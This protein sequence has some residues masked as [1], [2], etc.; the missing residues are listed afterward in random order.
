MP[1]F[2][3]QVQ[4]DAG[5]FL[6]ML[7]DRREEELEDSREITNPMRC[8]L[9][10]V[11]HT[12]NENEITP[13]QDFL[14]LSL[15]TKNLSRLD[16]VFAAYFEEEPIET[17]E[18]GIPCY[19]QTIV[20]RWSDYFVLQL[21]RWKFD[22][23]K[24]SNTKLMHE[25]QFPTHLLA[26]DLRRFTSCD[27]DYSLTG[28]VVHQGIMDQG[29]YVTI[30]Q[31]DFQE[32]Y[33]CDDQTIEYITL[34]Q[35]PG[36]AFGLEDDAPIISDEISTEY[37]LFYTRK[38]LD[39]VSISISLDL[40]TALNRENAAAWPQT[41]FYSPS[42]IKYVQEMALNNL[43]S[44]EAIQI[45]LNVFFRIVLADDD[46]ELQLVNEWLNI[47]TNRVLTTRDRLELMVEFMDEQIGDSP[48][49]FLRSS[50][51]SSI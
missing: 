50:M 41:I 40:E 6:N 4:E 51:Q 19:R 14:Y 12:G 2:N 38:G 18:S 1:S 16:D 22:M 36:W 27:F 24:R 47:L 11:I 31:G 35:L 26:A 43:S 5:E 9:T 8:Q 48:R 29:H 25:F 28:V 37:L 20:T 46:K 42:F 45:C 30:V 32:W 44:P 39:A 13:P 10:A 33:M 3:V 49:L 34:D 7:I 21:E 17:S 15:P 23:D